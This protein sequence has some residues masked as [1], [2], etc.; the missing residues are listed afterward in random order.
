VRF[1]A[2]TNIVAQAVSA[3]RAD[4]HD[5]VHVAEREVDPGD[6]ALLAEAVAE[7]R[8][9]VTKD[10]DIGTL[11]YRDHCQHRGVLLIDDLGDAASAT[12]LILSALA[13][14]GAELAAGA[15]LRADEAGVRGSAT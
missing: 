8:I 1:L 7:G 12:N 15:F 5:V 14:R 4:G 3:I 2:D 13:L 10:H 11:V 9:F 6:E